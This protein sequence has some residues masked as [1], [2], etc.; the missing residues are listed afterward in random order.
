MSA[1]PGT[2]AASRPVPPLVR[3]TDLTVRFVNHDA[4][5]HAVNGVS[6]DL[7]R[8]EVLGIL[9]ESGSGKSVTLKTLMRL[10]PARK[11]RLGGAI[12][13]AG[14]DVMALDARGLTAYRGSVVSM[15]FQEPM[16]AFDPVFSIG[17]QIAEAVVQHE[18]VSR[19]AGMQRALEML[20]RVQIPSAK[21]RLDA[22]PHEMSG[23]MRQRAMIALAL[24]CK[25]QLLLAD[26][27][28]TALDATVQIQILL[29][30]RELQKE[31]GMAVIFVTHDVGVAVEVSDRVAV[32]YA[33]R[34]IETG[35]VRDIIRNPRHPYSQGLLAANV[36]PGMA[37][38][39][40]GAARERIEAIPGSP[41]NMAKVPEGCAFAPRCKYAE[42]RCGTSFPP[43]AAVSASH[44]VHCIRG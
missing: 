30:L 32:M 10:L 42:E 36:L 5:V 40:V 31:F 12:N 14:Q 39:A 37:E 6:F 23:G 16:L 34:F 19:A 38:R 17:Y 44:Q 26:E 1:V 35:S 7:E 43:A 24:A 3:V 11:T 41:P 25:P 29:L 8:G 27:P 20:E 9:G 4:S 15:I 28:T 13:V 22:Y 21:R 33:G 2:N 18:G